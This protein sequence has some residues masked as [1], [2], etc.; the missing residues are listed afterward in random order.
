MT[1]K[2]KKIGDIVLYKP[3]FVKE[4]NEPN[5]LMGEMIMS[6]DGTHI[7]YSADIHTPYITLETRSD[8]GWLNEANVSALKAIWGDITSITITYDDD[9]TDTVRTAHEKQPVYAETSLGACYYNV[10]IPLAKVS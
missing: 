1:K 7:A 6:A 4:F 2:V 8:S 10:I 5:E 3:L 9:T